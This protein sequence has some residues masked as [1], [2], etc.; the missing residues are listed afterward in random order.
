MSKRL[1]VLVPDDEMA[2]IKRQAENEN[3]TIGEYVRVALREVAAHRPTK[4]A[5]MKLELIREAAQ[6]SLPTAD[7]E[8]MNREI[9]RG[10]LE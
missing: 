3:L 2:A 4:S 7:V 10:Y 9:E 1:Q 5:A 8:Q 6:L